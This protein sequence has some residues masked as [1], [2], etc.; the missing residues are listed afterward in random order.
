MNVLN[1]PKLIRIAFLGA[2]NMASAIAQGL[3]KTGL[4]SLYVSDIYSPAVLRWQTD[5]AAHVLN[6]TEDLNIDVLILAVKPQQFNE[7]V[8]SLSNKLSA[9]T[10]I[11]SVMAGISIDYIQSMFNGHSIIIRTMPNTPACIAQG[12]TALYASDRCHNFHKQLAEKIMRSVGDTLYVDTESQLDA[13][14]ALSG[15]GPAYL[16]YIAQ[17]MVDTGIQLGLSPAIAKQL[18]LKTLQGSATL[19]IDTNQDLTSLRQQVTSKG[20]TTE[21]AMNILHTQYVAQALNAA[22]L[23]ANTRAKELAQKELAQ[24]N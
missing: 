15:S 14:T 11:M 1:T 3:Y 24:F 2:G 4:Y 10:L 5:Y 19:A 7:A 21:A 16:F 23:A 6:V 9:H 22:I 12:M 18:V 13:V 20:G 17:A 8:Q